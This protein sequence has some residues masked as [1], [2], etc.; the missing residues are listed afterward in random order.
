MPGDDHSVSY[1]GVYA[2]GMTHRHY[3]LVAVRVLLNRWIS[4]RDDR[5][6]TT[7][8]SSAS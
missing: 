6:I 8:K 2:T 3:E 4:L 1:I 5:M 7:T